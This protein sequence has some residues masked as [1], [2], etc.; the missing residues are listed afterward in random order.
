MRCFLLGVLLGIDLAESVGNAGRECRLCGDV[1]RSGP[2]A[3]EDSI[4]TAFVYIQNHV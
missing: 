2:K 3:R 1:V 4:R